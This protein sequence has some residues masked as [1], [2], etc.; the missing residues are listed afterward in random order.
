[1]TKKRILITVKTYPTPSSKYEELVCT[2]G[3]DSQGNWV[4]IYPLPF[5]KL[6]YNQQYKKYHWIE[7]DLEKNSKDFRP[8]SYRPKNID[9][10]DVITYRDYLGPEN[11]WSKRKSIVLKNVFYDIGELI[12]KAKTKGVNI[13][14]AVFKPKEILSFV[15]EYT[16]SEWNDKQKSYLQQQNLFDSKD[17]FKILNK[18]PYKFIYEFIDIK[19]RKSKLQIIDWEIGALFWNCLKRNGGDEGAACDDVKKRYYNDFTKTKDLYFFLG[20]TLQFHSIAPNPF[21]I[22]G[23]FYPKKERMLKLNL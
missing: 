2:A 20:T 8:E 4:R 5:R 14:L 18:L 3:F 15:F 9:A 6:P 1:M 17:G 7:V 12:E 19:D 13:S 10:E 22:I 23:T 11:N 21:M 16:G